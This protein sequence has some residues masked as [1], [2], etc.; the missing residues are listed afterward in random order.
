VCDVSALALLNPKASRFVGLT[1][2]RCR[3]RFRWP[4]NIYI[5]IILYLYLIFRVD[6]IGLSNKGPSCR[7]VFDRVQPNRVLGALCGPFQSLL[8]RASRIGHKR[9]DA[10]YARDR[11]SYGKKRRNSDEEVLFFFSAE[12]LDFSK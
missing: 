9:M 8:S 4:S 3:V 6:S 12:Y 1:S 2:C 5:Y 7:E 11:E 10:I